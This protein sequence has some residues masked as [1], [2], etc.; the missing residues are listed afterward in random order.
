MKSE[1]KEESAST[2]QFS[3]KMVFFFNQAPLIKCFK[4]LKIS[5]P[6]PALANTFCQVIKDEITESTFLSGD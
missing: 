3:L 6:L 1:Y 2:L 4:F 5:F